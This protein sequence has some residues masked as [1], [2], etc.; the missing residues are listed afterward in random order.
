MFAK[1]FQI[2]IPFP[3]MKNKLDKESVKQNDN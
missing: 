3:D 1:S 2:S